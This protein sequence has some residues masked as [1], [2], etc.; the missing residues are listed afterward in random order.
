MGPDLGPLAPERQEDPTGIGYQKTKPAN[1]ID[2]LTKSA[3]PPRPVQIPG[4]AS[5][6]LLT[7]SPAAPHRLV[8]GYPSGAA[9]VTASSLSS[10]ITA[11]F[12]IL[13]VFVALSDP[14][15]SA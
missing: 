2:N 14:A 3:K 13:Y 10:T 1:T 6:P 12:C 8:I 11:A 9:A 4:G 5:T 7:H 15:V